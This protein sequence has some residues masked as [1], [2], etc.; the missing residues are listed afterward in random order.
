MASGRRGSLFKKKQGRS[1]VINRFLPSPEILC[2]PRR[3]SGRRE[4]YDDDAFGELPPK[5]HT[6]EN[7][8]RFSIATHFWIIIQQDVEQ[9]VMDVNVAVVVNETQFT[10]FVHERAHARPRGPDHFRERR[11]IYLCF[12]RLRFAILAK[13]RHKQQE[14][15]EAFFA[16]IEELIDQISLYAHV[17]R[18]QVGDEQFRKIGLFM[19]HALNGGNVEP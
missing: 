12:D 18:Q 7:L 3:G 4:I 14:S 5:V 19:D 17:A 10:E 6:L 13:I 15:C 9:R 2:T 1:P 16:G 11:L 8:V